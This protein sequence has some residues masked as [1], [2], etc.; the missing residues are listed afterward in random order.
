MA[1]DRT[2]HV[3]WN[4]SLME[5]GGHDR[6]RRQRR[7]RPARRH[8]GLARRGAVGQDE[9]RGADR[10]RACGVLLDGALA[11]ACGE[12]APPPERLST[13]AT[14]TF[15]PGEGITRSALT[16]EGSVP[17]IDEAGFARRGRGRQARMPGLE[18]ARR[19]PRDHARGRARVGPSPQGPVPSGPAPG[20]SRARAGDGPYL[21]R[22]ATID[23]LVEELER[24]YAEA[25]ERMSDPAVY[26]DHREAADAGRR[27]KEL[28]G[29]YKLALEWRRRATTSRRRGPTPSSR[30]CC[31]SWRSAGRPRG[32]AQARAGR[33]RPGRREGRPRRGA[34]GRRRRRGGPVGRR[35]PPHAHALRGAARLPHRDAFGERERRRRRQGGRLR[36]QGRR[37]LLGLQVGGRHA[38]RP[39][40][41]GD[42]VAGPHP[43]VDGDR[44]R[45][46]GGRG[47]RG[48]HRGEGP[49]DRRLPLDRPGWAERQHDRL[50][51]ADHARA[52]RD[53]RRDAGR[54]LAAPEPGEGDARAAGAPLR[55]GARAAA[56]RGGRARKAQVGSG[57]RA[58]KIRTYNFPE[59]RLTDHRSS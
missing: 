26:N 23:E 38:P 14:V 12:P 49:E 55:G 47:R 17:G 5:G 28:E 25:Q 36:R 34:A 4:G 22:V 20:V 42:R 46:A 37:R 43:H 45:D 29:P 56:R 30:R 24:S 31:P 16:V 51:G 41:P 32:G 54:A 19:H 9:P 11:R 33:A 40:G 18:G 52:D 59:N 50:G 39:A 35:C 27:L 57:E 10:R 13:S 15:Q 2:A 44:R 8:V 7:L 3:T 53:R 48:R 58:E 1:T 21:R 6:L